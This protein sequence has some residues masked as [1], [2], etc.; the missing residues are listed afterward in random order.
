M[1]FLPLALALAGFVP[2]GAD[3]GP[4]PRSAGSTFVEVK[5][6][7]GGQAQI[8]VE[9]GLGREITLVGKVR[10]G[11]AA[12]VRLQKSWQAGSIVHALSLGVTAE[13]E[14]RIAALWGWGTEIAAYPGWLSAEV[15]YAAGA[16]NAWQLS[17]EIGLRAPGRGIGLIRVWVDVSDTWQALTFQPAIGLE[18]R[19]GRTVV[20]SAAAEAGDGHDRRLALSLWLDF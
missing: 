6:E 8:Y 3:A 5:F 9:R 15:E 2:A 16:V 20:L 14:G 17:A 7:T 13:G 19:P 4:W 11:E 18:I 12:T 10:G 1:P